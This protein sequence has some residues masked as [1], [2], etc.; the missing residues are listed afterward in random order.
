MA[1]SHK[2]ALVI[3]DGGLPSLLAVWTEGV[4]RRP[5]GLAASLPAAFVWQVPGLGAAAR[6]AVERAAEIAGVDQA[7]DS[8]GL[9]V[10]GFAAPNS[11]GVDG[12]AWSYWL[13]QAAATAARKGLSRVVWPIQ[14]GSA[15]GAGAAGQVVDRAARAGDRALLAGRL[16]SLDAPGAGVTIETPYL[17]M[18]DSQVADLAADLDA[19]VAAAWW[20]IEGT[21]GNEQAEGEQ[22]T[23]CGRCGP[24]RRW[25]N[26][27]S[28]AGLLQQAAE[29]K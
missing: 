17:D 12:P 21:A 3:V 7:L 25:A 9:E 23:A 24:C 15:V 20:C 29:A 4:C 6:A 2:P 26:V 11:D 13:L 22:W 1:E 27:L 16:A 18:T 8:D 10:T 5:P 19:P 28:E 14:L